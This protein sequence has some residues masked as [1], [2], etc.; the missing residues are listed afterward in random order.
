LE[1]LQKELAQFS[2]SNLHQY[3]FA[4]DKEKVLVVKN[5]ESLFKKIVSLLSSD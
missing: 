5:F 4:S 1:N 3:G 2:V